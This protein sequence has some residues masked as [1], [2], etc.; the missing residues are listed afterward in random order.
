MTLPIVPEIHQR[1]VLSI[2]NQKL[3]IDD[4]DLMDCDVGIQTHDDGR[5]WICV[6]G[7]AFI[8]FKPRR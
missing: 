4:F 6:N 5:I 3:V 1:G 7:I 8:R 2:E